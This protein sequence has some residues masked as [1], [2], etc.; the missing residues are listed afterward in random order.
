MFPLILT[1]FYTVSILGMEGFDN[2]FAP[3]PSPTNY[4]TYDAYSSFRSLLQS[5]LLCVQFMIESSWSYIT[6]DYAVRYDN[7]AGAVAFFSFVHFY[8]V[9]VLI[10]LMKGMAADFYNAIN[11]KHDELV[12]VEIGIIER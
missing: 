4:S 9:L 8:L 7:F 6:L 3:V 5:H 10:S 1:C 2:R 11:E 12:A